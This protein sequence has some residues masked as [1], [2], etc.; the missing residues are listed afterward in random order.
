MERLTKDHIESLIDSEDFVIEEQY[1]QCILTV[2]EAPVIGTSYRFSKATHDPDMAKKAA[3][4]DAIRQLFSLEAYHQKR[5]RPVPG[6][7]RPVGIKLGNQFEEPMAERDVPL[8]F[9]GINCQEALA[10]FCKTNDTKLGE[11]DQLQLETE[12]LVAGLNKHHEVPV[13]SLALKIC[14]FENRRQN[15]VPR[16]LNIETMEEVKELNSW[17]HFKPERIFI[18]PESGID[19]SLLLDYAQNTEGRLGQYVLVGRGITGVTTPIDE[20][21][22]V[23]DTNSFENAVNSTV[24]RIAEIGAAAKKDVDTFELKFETQPKTLFEQRNKTL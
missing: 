14:E 7:D 15:D 23:A 13:S 5:L 20:S 18:D 10:E 2:G 11:K 22:Y 4:D 21:P 19:T 24:S 6:Q 16:F 12:N 3:R 9:N 17:L 1:V 8:M